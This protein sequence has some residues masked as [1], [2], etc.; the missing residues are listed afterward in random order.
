MDFPMFSYVCEGGVLE[1]ATDFMDDT[2]HKFY[3]CTADGVEVIEE[4]SCS[5]TT[6][7]WSRVKSGQELEY[8]TKE[9][10][11]AILSS[12]RRLEPDMKPIT[13]YPFK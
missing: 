11:Q 7:Y 3:R 2:Y 12:Y 8:I 6:G 4:I 13:A 10:V 5:P 9:E 1:Y